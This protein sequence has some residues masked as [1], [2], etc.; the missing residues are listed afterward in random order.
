MAAAWMPQRQTAKRASIGGRSF[1]GKKFTSVGASSLWT[2]ALGDNL[3]KARL[4]SCG[5]VYSMLGRIRV[6]AETRLIL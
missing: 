3:R 5:V 1:S 4:S 2:I 6:D